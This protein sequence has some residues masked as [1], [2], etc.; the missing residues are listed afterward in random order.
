MKRETNKHL[1]WINDT[2]VVVLLEVMNES[3]W[4]QMKTINGIR[5]REDD[6]KDDLNEIYIF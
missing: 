4:I 2:V 6:L 1:K 5:E 3:E